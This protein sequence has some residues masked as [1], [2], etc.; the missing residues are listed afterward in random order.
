MP[1]RGEQRRPPCAR[2]VQRVGLGVGDDVHDAAAPAVG[3]RAAERLH[4]DVL[5]GDR[6]DD[7]RA[8]D[9]DPAGRRP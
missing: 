7:V 9:E 8:G 1:W 4:V 2:R 5:A 3:V 6:A